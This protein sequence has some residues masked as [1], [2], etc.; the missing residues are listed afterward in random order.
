MTR[1]ARLCFVFTSAIAAAV[2]G[3][4]VVEAVSNS[5][6]AWRGAYTDRSSLDL[7]PMS[8]FAALMFALVVSL[9]M[10]RELAAGRLSERALIIAVSRLFGPRDVTR[11]LGPT[12]LLQIATLF[13]METVEQSIV[14]GHPL[15]GALWLGGPMIASLIIHFAL[16]VA[17]AF[18]L[19][20]A[21]ADFAR[22]VGKLVRWLA[23]VALPR[24]PVARAIE[25]DVPSRVP[26][27][28]LGKTRAQR[29]PPRFALRVAL[30]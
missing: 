22:A 13:G 14:Y 24:R 9:M 1:A 26:R 5:L 11:L 20:R 17:C 15:G 25:P 12:F 18:G 7:L 10:R 16:G 2:I 23:P 3:D 8:L 19:A 30:A 4:A 21:L 27:L 28:L 6:I 29:G